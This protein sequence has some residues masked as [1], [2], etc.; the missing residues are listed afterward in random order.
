M[1]SGHVFCLE[2]EEVEAAVEKAV[3]AGAVSEG[4][5][6]AD[7]GGRV[8]KVQDPYGNAWLISSPAKVSTEVEA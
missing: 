4:I 5:S 8:A 6:E 2:T 7:C 1:G 3:K